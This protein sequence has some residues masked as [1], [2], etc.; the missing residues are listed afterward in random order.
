MIEID[1]AYGQGGG[2]ILRTS[3]ALSTLLG[4]PIMIDKIRV[5]RAKPGLRPQHL[6]G[7]KALG[8]ISDAEIHGLKIG[9][10]KII[11]TPHKRKGGTLRFDV[12]TAGSISLVLQALLPVMAFPEAP[13]NLTIIGGS[14]TQWSPPYDYLKEMILP[15]LSKMGYQAEMTLK[16]RGHYPKGGGILNM[17]ITPVVYLRPIRFVEGAKIK[18]ISLISHCVKLPKHVAERQAKSALEILRK[19][20]F[21]NVDVRLEWYP[22]E[23]D[24]HFGPG[25]GIV[26]W[27]ETESGSFLGADALGERRKRAEKVGEEAANNFVSELKT[28]MPIDQHMG[29]ILVPYVAIAKGKS[30]YAVSK[31]TLH[32]LTNIYVT[33]KIVGVKF[34]VQGEEGFPGTI[35]VEGIGLEN[36]YI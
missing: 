28:G 29:D 26:I 9:S 27:A 7:V 13:I 15:I 19:N 4:E 5:D 21:E 3:V 2:Q 17:K 14:D 8:T 6:T 18:R 36:E 10:T 20:G 11:F 24:P 31:I 23:K 30:E 34:E 16:R 25:S 22:K 33:E 12:R 35:K 1:G 32:T